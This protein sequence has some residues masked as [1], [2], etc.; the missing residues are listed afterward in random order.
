MT[1]HEYVD[2][3]AGVRSPRA[4]MSAVGLCALL[5]PAAGDLDILE[6]QANSDD[7]CDPARVDGLPG[8]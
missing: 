4:F 3:G 8:I 5:H 1:K 6:R 7:E 2:S